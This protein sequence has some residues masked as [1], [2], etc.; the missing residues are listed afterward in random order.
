MYNDVYS[1]FLLKLRH[2]KEILLHWKTLIDRKEFNEI[3]IYNWGNCLKY[4][5][6]DGVTC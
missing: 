5:S 1:V 4:V 6:K 2:D 3:S